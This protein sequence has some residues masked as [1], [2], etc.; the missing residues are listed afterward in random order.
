MVQHGDY[1]VSKCI[2]ALLVKV[3]IIHKCVLHQNVLDLGEETLSL[4]LTMSLACSMTVNK[5]IRLSSPQ[6]NHL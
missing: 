6:F 1:Q 5:P 3:I 2:L 4:A